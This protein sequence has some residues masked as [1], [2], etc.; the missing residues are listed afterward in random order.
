MGKLIVIE[1]LDGSGKATQTALLAENLN[2]CGEVV[3][4]VS[5]PNYSSDSSALI[6]MYLAGQFGSKP[7]DVNAYAA[8]AFYAVDRYA[9][10]KQDWGTFLETQG[11]VLADR[12][13]TSNAVHQ[14]CKLEKPNRQEFLDW[15]D[16]FEY[17]KLGIPKPD[18]VV[19]LDVE[20]DVS[21]GLINKRY[22]GET[23]KQDIHE[24]DRAYQAHCR[25]VA[26]WC[27]K[28]LG[29]NVVKCSIGGELRTVQD[30]ASEVFGIVQNQM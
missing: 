28:Q 25:E 17:T 13:T 11:H 30:I 24:A 16:D 21:L 8:S 5:F 7:E 2:Q 10:W 12:Y 26:L 22:G 29:W 6:K 19:Y 4:T 15:L 1:G 3:K 23:S 9:G 27:A 18:V 20:P 14:C